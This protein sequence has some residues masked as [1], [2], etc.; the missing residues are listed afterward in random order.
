M[1]MMSKLFSTMICHRMKNIMYI[2]SVVPDVLEEADMHF[3]LSA[4][5]KCAMIAFAHTISCIHLHQLL[6]PFPFWR[7]VVLLSVALLRCVS[8]PLARMKN[9]LRILAHSHL[10]IV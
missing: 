2:V 7:P 3:L 6:V 10:E 9:S 5:K 4:E 8:L 1:S